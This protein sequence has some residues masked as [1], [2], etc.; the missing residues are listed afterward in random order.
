MTT[1]SNSDKLT[2]VDQKIKNI[3]YQKYGWEIDL[4]LANAVS[5]PDADDIASISAKL[6]DVE[7]KLSILNAE[8]ATLE[9]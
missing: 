5:S 1:L 3:E 6:S 7:A 8:K 4:Q 9:E 2:I